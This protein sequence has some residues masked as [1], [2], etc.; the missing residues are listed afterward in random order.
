MSEPTDGDGRGPKVLVDRAWYEHA[1][2]VLDGRNGC[3]FCGDT[4][5]PIVEKASETFESRKGCRACDRW[6][7]PVQLKR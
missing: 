1:V 3:P 4:G 6:W 2:S 7:S 5:A